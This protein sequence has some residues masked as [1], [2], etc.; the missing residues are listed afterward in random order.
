MKRRIAPLASLL[1][2]FSILCAL[3]LLFGASCPWL[4]PVDR[5]PPH[6]TM[7]APRDSTVVSGIVTLEASA[8]DTSGVISLQFL[9]DDSVIGDGT[10]YGGV[11]ELSWNTAGLNERSAHRVYARAADLYDNVGYSDTSRVTVITAHD[12]DVYHGEINVPS[13]QYVGRSF[14]ANEGDSLLGDARVLNGVTLADFFWCDLT[15]YQ[16][17]QRHQSFTA[18]DRQQSV[19]NIT[20]AGRVAAT[21][22]YYLVFDN[23]AGT[24]RS[25]WAR[26]LLRRRT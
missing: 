18:L 15:N 19:A 5:T 26:F 22:T 16:E 21:G 25:L 8:A 10:E 17:F 14:G 2:P 1:H 13:G 20:V 7:I 6:V 24:T 9:V 11:Y 3:C 12:I 4:L 23:N